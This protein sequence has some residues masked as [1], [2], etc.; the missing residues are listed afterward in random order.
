MI[1]ILLVLIAWW[2]L[3]GLAVHLAYREDKEKVAPS[4]RLALIFGPF[5]GIHIAWKIR[6]LHEKENPKPERVQ[7]QTRADRLRER[8]CLE[9]EEKPPTLLRRL[10]RR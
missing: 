5:T 9:D 10:F 3:V 8:T 4:L 6:Q 2:L 7:A 1:R